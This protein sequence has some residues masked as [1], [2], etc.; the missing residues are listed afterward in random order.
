MVLGNA[1]ASTPAAA[2]GIAVF[3]ALLAALAAPSQAFHF[4]AA[5][6][7]GRTATS[8]SCNYRGPGITAIPPTTFHD[9][10]ALRFLYVRGCPRLMFDNVAS[11]FLQRG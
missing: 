10:A 11:P 3:F 8:F 4:C 9:A 6:A 7:P 5:H 1:T 2:A